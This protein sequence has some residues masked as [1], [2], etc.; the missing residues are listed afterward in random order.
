MK[1]VL[2]AGADLTS[3]DRGGRL[4]ID[5]AREARLE[6]LVAMMAGADSPPGLSPEPVV[7]YTLGRS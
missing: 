5:V 2:D 7:A 4:P 6:K 1:A 3:K